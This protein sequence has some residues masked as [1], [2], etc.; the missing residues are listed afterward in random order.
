ML[1]AQNT[2]QHHRHP[3]RLSF[4]WATTNHFSK[5]A[6]LTAAWRWDTAPSQHT[7][8]HFSGHAVWQ[9]HSW[10][11]WS[12]ETHQSTNIS[13]WAL[14]NCLGRTKI[15]LL[16]YRD[17]LEHQVSQ[18]F[19]SAMGLFQA[20]FLAHLSVQHNE[21]GLT[22]AASHTSFGPCWLLLIWT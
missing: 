11:D 22:G 16:C 6:Q 1:R 14:F 12:A 7:C 20:G 17:P 21:F 13:I 3:N 9:K 5:Q 4:T 15:R 10:A 18:A 19:I 8:W 2:D